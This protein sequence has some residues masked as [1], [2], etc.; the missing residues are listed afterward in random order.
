MNCAFADG[1]VH[2]LSYD[3]G[4][5]NLNRLGNFADSETLGNEVGL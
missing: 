2:S 5:E 3:I 1:S 4:N